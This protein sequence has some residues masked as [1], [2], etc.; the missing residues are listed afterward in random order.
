MRS[1]RL[2]EIPGCTENTED[3]KDLPQQR[4]V[5]TSTANL[6]RSGFLI[7]ACLITVWGP[8]SINYIIVEINIEAGGICFYSPFDMS[9][10]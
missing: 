5:H 9:L 1:S 10:H 2:R 3:Q 4:Q 6:L 8:P 7:A